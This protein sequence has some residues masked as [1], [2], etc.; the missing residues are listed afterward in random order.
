MSNPTLLRAAIAASIDRG[1]IA[2]ASIFQK[3]GE[4]T[5]SVLPQALS[6]FSFLF[7]IDRDLNRAH[8]LRGGLAAPTLTMAADS[9]GVMQ[10]AA[11]RIALDLREAGF[12]VV[13]AGGSSGQRPDLTLRR[14]TLQGG[15]PSAV[16]D[17]VL[18][19]DA[20]ETPAGADAES[21]GALQS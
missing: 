17:G 2:N 21:R 9:D 12:N 4:A 5:G 18:R 7:P 19:E 13:V 1:A 11:Q 6:G 15:A 20:H 3:Q 14:M 10:L 8:A 16:L